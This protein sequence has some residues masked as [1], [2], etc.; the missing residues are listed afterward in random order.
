MNGVKFNRRAATPGT[1]SR[2]KPTTSEGLARGPYLA[3]R[4]G[5]ERATVHTEDAEHHHSATTY[6]YTGRVV[7]VISRFPNRRKNLSL[8]TNAFTDG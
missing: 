5:F 3:A 1:I 6:S 8:E 4:V 7:T 2:H